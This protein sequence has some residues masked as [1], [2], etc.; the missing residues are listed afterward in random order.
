RLADCIVLPDGRKL[1][2]YVITCTVEEI[3]GVRQ[4]QVIQETDGSIRIR[5]LS[6]RLSANPNHVK[7]VVEEQLDKQVRVTVEVLPELLRESN[8]KYKVVVSRIGADKIRTASTDKEL[9][10]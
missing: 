7:A 6:S 3:P 1:S 9:I 2:P 8:G 10:S 4:F 5:L